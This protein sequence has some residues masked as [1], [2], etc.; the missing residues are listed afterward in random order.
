MIQAQ[1]KQYPYYLYNGYNDY[2]EAALSTQPTGYIVMA[3]N[4]ISQATEESILYSDAEYIGLTRQEVNDSYVIEYQ[5]K[6]LKVKYVNALGRL[7]QV[8]LK[9]M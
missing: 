9:G 1:M 5:G 2:G 7:K 4:I 3:I 6:K 8:F